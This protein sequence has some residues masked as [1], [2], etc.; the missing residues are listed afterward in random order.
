M[1]LLD[2]LRKPSD[3]PE[4]VAHKHL[5][6]SLFQAVNIF[7]NPDNLGTITKVRS[8]FL[9]LFLDQL[10]PEIACAANL[11]LID[12]RYAER[13]VATLWATRARNAPRWSPTGLFGIST[14]LP[15]IPTPETDFEN[16]RDASNKC[17][18]AIG[19]RIPN[20]DSQFGKLG[21][22]LIPLVDQI[23]RTRPLSDNVLGY[24][25]VI[26]PL[27]YVEVFERNDQEAARFLG[28]IVASRIA[29]GRQQRILRATRSFQARIKPTT[30][31]VQLIRIALDLLQRYSNAADV[32][33]FLEG[34]GGQT[35][36]VRPRARSKLRI[37]TSSRLVRA[38][39]RRRS[40]GHRVDAINIH[41][42]F[43]LALEADLGVIAPSIPSPRPASDSDSPLA[44]LLLRAFAE[45]TPAGQRPPPSLFSIQLLT[46][47]QHKPIGGTFSSTDVE[48]ASAL[49][50]QLIVA[51]PA[52][53]LRHSLGR[54]T[55]VIADMRQAARES[56]QRG[57]P[58]GGE[59]QW[60]NQFCEL[61]AEV[62]PPIRR[63]FLCHRTAFSGTDSLRVTNSVGEEVMLPLQGHWLQG[64]GQIGELRSIDN[65]YFLPVTVYFTQQEALGI[66]LELSRDRL[67]N[68]ERTLIEFVVSELSLLALGEL[69]VS[70]K[71]RQLAE[72][73]HH[74]K[75]ELNAFLGNIRLVVDPTYG[76]AA[77]LYN[78]GD[79]SRAASLIFREASFHKALDDA[80]DSATQIS[81]LFESARVLL[82]D[83]TR[84]KLQFSPGN[85]ARLV[86]E[87][88]RNLRFEAERRDVRVEFINLYP[89]ELPP[90]IVDRNW[91]SVCISNLVDNAVKYSFSGQ[92]VE[93]VL[94]VQRNRWYLT[95]RN[96]GRHIPAERVSEIF[97][98]FR[99]LTQSPGQQAMPGTGIGLAAVRE[100]LRLHDE[101][102]VVDV[103][104]DLL[105]DL[106]GPADKALTT[107]TISLRRSLSGGGGQSDSRRDSP[108]SAL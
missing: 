69:D 75:N 56:R 76:Q 90:P 31:P 33:C 60:L 41:N 51:I 43:D 107:F 100:I 78:K 89:Q 77:A 85:M 9:D 59:Q 66:V 1:G 15:R 39:L 16:F 54:L 87:Q 14:D 88:I 6:G 26:G 2:W 91:I 42:V 37:P 86:T 35:V 81:L 13:V 36:I 17:L 72:I 57:E 29:F 108:N 48:I 65:H 7:A 98:P 105:R 46:T 12:Q 19:R 3:Q 20:F 23:T 18:S 53:T 45:A 95:V 52:A 68:H 24:V 49:M 44:M 84:D 82:G 55:K 10:P 94:G 64:S 104:S 70:D 99:R 80:T 96:I 50:E 4:Q 28:T 30:E 25:Q 47:P 102:A 32:C 67:H 34:S 106:S 93:V 74:V 8:E 62:V 79:E 22:V 92:S 71:L 27:N 58:L 40:H 38:L 5:Q 61:L 63:W 21:S 97:L 101:E 103:K 83:M 11:W 73:R